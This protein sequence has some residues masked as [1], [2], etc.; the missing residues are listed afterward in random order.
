[1][2]RLGLALLLVTA[3][4]ADDDG[5]ELREPIGVR[6]DLHTRVAVFGIPKRPYAVAWPERFGFPAT[7]AGDTVVRVV[8]LSNHGEGCLVLLGAHL[9]GPD[10]FAWTL[11]EA[12]GT[13][14]FGALRSRVEI[15]EE[16]AVEIARHGGRSTSR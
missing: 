13:E 4:C 10:D 9:D 6:C 7:A 16:G 8:D 12:D 1:M 14:H 5:D 15:P 11:T 2:K 3:G